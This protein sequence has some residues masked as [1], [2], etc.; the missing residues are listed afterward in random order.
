MKKEILLKS[1]LFILLPFLFSCSKK[2]EESAVPEST[3]SASTAPISI[4]LVSTPT[5]EPV[6]TPE[7]TATPRPTRIP[8]QHED[9]VPPY[10]IAW[11][12]D[13][14]HYCRLNNG[15][16]EKMTR[17]LSDNRDALNL[18]YIIHTGDLVHNRDE[19]D[20]WKIAE[21]CM[22]TIQD[23]PNGV[24]AGNHDVGSTLEEQ[25]Y[26]YFCSH[27]GEAKYSGK[28]WYGGTL[29]D[30][31]DHYDLLSIG[32]TDFIF[33]YLGFHVTKEDFDW[34]NRILDENWYRTAVLCTHD[35][36][37]TELTLTEYGQQI[38]DNVVKVSPNI[39]MVLCGHRY[40]C[41]CIPAEIDDDNDGDADR[42]VIQM[43]A[44]YQAI[45]A[46]DDTHRTGG[47][48]YMILFTV[49]EQDGNIYYTSYSP[50]KND[51]IYFDTK[52]HHQEKYA[53]DPENEEGSFPIPWD[54][55]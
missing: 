42:T 23:I 19:E 20:Q 32:N 53:F 28:E 8:R 38:Y 52:K 2:G 54:L 40:N 34:A 18:K 21:K 3:A 29:N 22:D 7:V 39:R 16:F 31:K 4:A 43:I 13:T 26:K 37:S 6:H 46:S 10:T 41:A 44:N 24:V 5:P 36:F 1:V 11:I 49:N 35:Y 47:E 27:F 33:I 15:V 9:D 30:N 12:S 17:Y 50:Y 51:K 45:G 48:G 14:Q 55:S 25:D